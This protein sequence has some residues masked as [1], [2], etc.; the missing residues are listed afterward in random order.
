MKL[1]AFDISL[2]AADFSC[3]VCLTSTIFHK[4]EADL[5]PQEVSVHVDMA[6]NGDVV[7]LCLYPQPQAA[8]GCSM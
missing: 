1:T 2:L 8:H 6:S 3:L 4:D 5:Q 7:K